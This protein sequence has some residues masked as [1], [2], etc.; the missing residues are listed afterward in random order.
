MVLVG[1]TSG[2]NVPWAQA[3]HDAQHSGS[4]ALAGPSASRA[5]VLWSSATKGLGGTWP[6]VGAEGMA[7]QGLGNGSVAAMDVATGSVAWTHPGA[8]GSRAWASPAVSAIGLLYVPA[9]SSLVA[10]H[11]ADGTMAWTLP[12]PGG[13]VGAPCLG[14]GQAVY[15]IAGPNLHAISTS[16]TAGT[17]LWSYVGPANATA[18]PVVSPDGLSVMFGAE[19]TIYGLNTSSGVGLWSVAVNN[20]ILS[21]LALD[22][23]GILYLV[24]TAGLVCLP[25]L[26]C[27]PACDFAGCMPWTCN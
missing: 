20:S 19:A 8:G 22:A 7:Y 17:L 10:L 9:A 3:G 27:P 1:S 13:P 18:D 11:L 5:Q 24:T 4:T 12:L 25:T 6:V 14:V 16:E 15:L 21:P 23:D 2:A 26:S